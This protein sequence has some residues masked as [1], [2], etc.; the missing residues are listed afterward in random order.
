VCQISS[1]LPEFYRRYYRIHFGLSFFWTHCIARNW[2]VWSIY[3]F[4]HEFFNLCQ[5]WW[6]GSD[7][8]ALFLG[9]SV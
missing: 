6:R 2:P 1:E 3:R 7:M 8:A 5:Y 9:H 4:I